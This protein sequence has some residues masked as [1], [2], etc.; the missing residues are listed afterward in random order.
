MIIAESSKDVNP[1]IHQEAYWQPKLLS[2]EEDVLAI[3]NE[4]FPQR[5]LTAHKDAKYALKSCYIIWISFS[6]PEVTTAYFK[7]VTICSK[8]R[9]HCSCAADQLLAFPHEWMYVF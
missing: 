3:T 7:Q 5:L 9:S 4:N 8:A 2:S 1:G 6:D